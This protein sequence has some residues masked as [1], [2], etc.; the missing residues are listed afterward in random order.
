MPLL[1]LDIETNGLD[2]FTCD[3]VTLQLLPSS[4]DPILIK[5]PATLGSLKPLL[6]KNIIVGQNLKFD[7]KFLKYQ[8]GI[9]L[10]NVYDTYIAELVLSGGLL[11]SK[12]GASLKDLVYKYC[13]T[14]LDKS[15]QCTF[16]KGEPLT[17]EQAEYAVNDLR[18]LPQIMRRQQ[19]EIL[20]LGLESVIETEMRAIPAVVWL[21]LS[22]INLDLKLIEAIRK[23]VIQDKVEAKANLLTELQQDTGQRTIMGGVIKAPLNLDSSRELLEALRAKSFDLNSTSETELSLYR[24]NPIIK[25][26]LK[27]RQA[28]KML[29]GFVDPIPK[30]RNE[31]TGRIHAN[32][33][34]FGAKSGRF[35]SSNPNLQQQ[36]TAYNWRSVFVAAPGNKLVTA[37]YSQIELRIIGQVSGD[38]EF[39]KA[40][41]EGQDL[42]KLTASKIFKL[43]LDKV[44]KEQRSIAKTVNF[45]IAYGMWTYGLMGNL[46]KAGIEIT[47]KE[48][49]N[50]IKGFYKAYPDVAK[51]LD[52][53]SEN[54][55]RNLHVRNAAGRLM[56]FSRPQNEKEKSGIKRESKNLPIQSLCADML[57]IAIGNLFLK[58]EPMGIK[59]V[60]T[61]HDEVVFECSE[62]QVEE[63]AAIVKEEM[64]KAG[65]Q[66]LKNL[67]CIAEIT[68]SEVWKK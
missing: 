59:F 62:A 43:S 64:E 63:V 39:L 30:Y 2:P 36:P 34:Q 19:E 67:P 57:K 65:K 51:Y 47:E 13:G 17:Q 50:V 40:Y 38:Q 35:T 20:S 42:H 3:L 66:Y 16:K 45:G 6:E 41:N 68:I 15:A 46:T 12:R 4:G 24:E 55:L 49:K 27:Y 14:V 25:S 33:N 21:E 56:K 10:Y 53:I 7:S 1:Y 61:V 52:K 5:D 44:T 23:D 22:G 8:Y 60:N 48:A 58:L 31:K 9:T 28:T 32:F 18:Y 26:V 29:S 11:A 54:G 37:D